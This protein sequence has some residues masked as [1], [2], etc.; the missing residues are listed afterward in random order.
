LQRDDVAVH[1]AEFTQST[2]LRIRKKNGSQRKND[3]VVQVLGVPTKYVIECR[4]EQS[5]S[6]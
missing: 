6:K 5:K 2:C 4:K 3:V 1:I